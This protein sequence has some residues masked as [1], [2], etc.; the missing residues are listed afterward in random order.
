M[1]EQQEKL[2]LACGIVKSLDE[3]ARQHGGK[4]GRRSQCK[5]CRKV[6]DVA[7]VRA[8][9]EKAKAYQSSY[10][11]ANRE[12][13]RVRDRERDKHRKSKPEYRE[14]R[15]E[16]NKIQYARNREKYRNFYLKKKYSLTEQEYQQ[17]YE[18]QDG[19]CAICGN[20]PNSDG[21]LAVDHDHKSGLVR[22]LLCNDC[23][24]GI[25]RLGDDVSRLESAV[26][27]LRRYQSYTEVL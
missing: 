15:A 9:S 23:N 26:A 6:R 4:Y 22:G 8:N 17:M 24:I 21:Q 19:L 3:F 10:R 20:P 27:Y 14:R 2:C 16:L 5:A 1:S 18:A 7:Y 25:G 12:R 13:L 11:L